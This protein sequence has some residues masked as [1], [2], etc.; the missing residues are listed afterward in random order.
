MCIALLVLISL[1]GGCIGGDEE[2]TTTP[3]PTTTQP[4]VT[5]RDGD[6]VPDASDACPDI[7]GDPANEGCP[8]TTPP[9]TTSAPTT[10]AP[11]TTSAPT[12]T[13]PPDYYRVTYH[14]AVEADVFGQPYIYNDAILRYLEEEYEETEEFWGKY[15][16]HELTLSSLNDRTTDFF[17]GDENIVMLASDALY[18][19][20]DDPQYFGYYWNIDTEKRKDLMLKSLEDYDDGWGT[21]RL[22]TGSYWQIYTRD[23]M[24]GKSYQV[25]T[26]NTNKESPRLHGTNVIY[27]EYIRDW[28]LMLATLT[29]GS[30]RT[31]SNMDGDEIKPLIHEDLVVFVLDNATPHLYYMFLD[32]KDPTLLCENVGTYVISEDR[33]LYYDV[34]TTRWNIIVFDDK[35]RKRFYTPTGRD[36]TVNVAISESWVY[37]DGTVYK[38]KAPGES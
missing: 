3:A 32:D 25:T 37:I 38:I 22:R 27:C 15:N 28:D 13:A 33:I 20:V 1:I 14:D 18:I 30:N 16:L 4:P 21:Y 29:G 11:P 24:G 19:P 6:G 26:T 17:Y 5:D 7:P 10:T 12:T 9:P 8:T 2:S 23:I 36:D 31:L 34:E 35:A